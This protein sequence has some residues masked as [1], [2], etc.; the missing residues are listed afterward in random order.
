MIRNPLS[1]PGNKNRLLKEIIPIILKTDCF[2]DVFCGSGVVGVNSESKKIIMNDLSVWAT[3]INKIL[4]EKSFEYIVSEIEKRIKLYNLTYTREHEKGFYTEI[5]HEGLSRYNLV[6]Y[7]ALKDH[8]NQSHDIMDLIVLQIYGFN[9]YIRFNKK[10]EF[11]VP[12]GKV[13]FS[14][15]IYKDLKEYMKILKTKEVTFTNKDFREKSISDI[16]K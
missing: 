15:S 1:Y 14:E 5:K 16:L 11:N 8:F 4:Y 10:S 6:G 12:V 13:D 3:R 9:H 7:N 2:V